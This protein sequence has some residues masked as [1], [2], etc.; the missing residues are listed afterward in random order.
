[1]PA[2]ISL[3]INTTNNSLIG[4]LSNSAVVQPGQ[5]PLFYGDTVT[6]NI[7]LLAALQGTNLAPGTF[8]FSQIST[9]GLTLYMFLDNGVV[10]PT[11][12][13]Q[14][15]SWTPDP[16]GTF[17]TANV[18]LLT[19]ALTALLGAGT[20]ASAWLQIGY[21]Q[22]GLPTTVFSKQV[23]VQVGMPTANAPTVPAGQTALSLETARGLFVPI[24]GLPAGQPFF[25]TSPAGHT[26]IYQ[27]VDNPDGT[28]SVQ[29]SQIN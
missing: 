12:Y 4:G 10:S 7:Y 15:I 1:M 27:I 22:N 14:Q 11:I 6:M 8:P 19:A 23:N 16:T 29:V 5:I 20:N 3:F 2:N 9:A 24:N 17:W 25:Q 26:F 21:I 28:A 13:T 18:S